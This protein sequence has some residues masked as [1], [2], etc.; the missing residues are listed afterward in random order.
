MTNAGLQI[1]RTRSATIAAIRSIIDDA[2]ESL[3]LAVPT[4]SLS[5]FTPQL[6]DAI[7]R[8]VLV[9]LLLHGDG[10]ATDP[11][12]RDIATAVRTAE[13]GV[14]PLLVTADVQRGLTGNYRLL[15][16]RDVAG[17]A[18]AFDNQN[19]AHDQFTMFLGNH[20][21][22]A[23]ERYV[24]GVCEF[25]QRVSAF[26]FALLMAALA[27]QEEIPLAATADV[28][29]TTDRTETT[30]S[31]PVT[32]VRQSIISPASSTNPA[33]RSL[34][35]ETDAGPVTVGGSG[36]SKEAYECREITLERTDGQ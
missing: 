20:W 17:Q 4:D 9:L 13:T 7:E 30:V 27:L 18:T 33:E 15:T 10:A 1:H 25:P 28:V 26:Q 3:L 24:A 21:Q 32:N 14:T 12:Y 36:A 8:D 6:R 11:S 31:G 29:S 19:L 22:T 34:T 5:L 35:I 2:E 23:T 16:D